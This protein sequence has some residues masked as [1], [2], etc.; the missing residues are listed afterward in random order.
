MRYTLK[1][2]YN[3]MP[4]RRWTLFTRILTDLER[5][6][7]KTYLKQ[8]GEKTVNIQVLVTRARKHLPQIRADVDLLE[9][10]RETYERTK[11]K[12]AKG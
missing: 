2:Y 5:R 10:V 4:I 11:A 12:K 8:N 1:A 6:Q 7:A 9:K 3:S